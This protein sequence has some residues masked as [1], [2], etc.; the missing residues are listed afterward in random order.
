MAKATT[1]IA[2]AC[3]ALASSAS[4][5]DAL[6]LAETFDDGALGGWTHTGAEKYGGAC[7]ASDGWATTA[8][9]ISAT[10]SRRCR[11]DAA[12]RTTDARGVM[13]WEVTRETDG[14]RTMGFTTRREGDREEGEGHG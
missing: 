3:A 9:A 8:R 13:G 2:L 11:W 10:G 5:A 6:K 7:A 1:V 4:S 14:G 12:R